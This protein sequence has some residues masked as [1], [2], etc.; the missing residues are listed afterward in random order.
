[1]KTRNWVRGEAHPRAKLTGAQVIE[2]RA[3]KAPI[4]VL[5]ANYGVSKQHIR[6]LKQLQMWTH[7]G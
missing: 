1:M 2:I 5:A 7:I 6:K 4:K 3:S